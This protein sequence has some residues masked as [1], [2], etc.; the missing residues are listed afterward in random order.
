MN[1]VWFAVTRQRQG[2]WYQGTDGTS[3]DLSHLQRDNPR[4]LPKLC[5]AD[6]NLL[7]EFI[8]DDHDDIRCLAMKRYVETVRAIKYQGLAVTIADMQVHLRDAQILIDDPQPGESTY[9]WLA[10]VMQYQHD[11]NRYN[12]VFYALPM[13]LRHWTALTKDHT[14]YLSFSTL[15]YLQYLSDAVELRDWEAFAARDPETIL[16]TWNRYVFTIAR[17]EEDKMVAAPAGSH[18]PLVGS[19]VTEGYVVNQEVPRHLVGPQPTLV[20][21]LAKPPLADRNVNPAFTMV[22]RTVPLDVLLA[23]RTAPGA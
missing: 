7:H 9:G 3:G 8:T 12:M 23:S 11:F 18:T 16:A 14:M 5:F 17:P 21:P 10:K 13:G 15:R 4:V 22:P 6:Q 2:W 1:A 20:V 19:R